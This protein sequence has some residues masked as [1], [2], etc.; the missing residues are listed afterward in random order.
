MKKILNND[1]QELLQDEFDK[2]YYQNLRKFLVS[3]YKTKTIYPDMHNIF[4]ALNFTAFKDVK[5][6]IL[7]QVL[8]T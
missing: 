3:E 7:G 8:L 6:V 5:V 1:W 4:N 2:D